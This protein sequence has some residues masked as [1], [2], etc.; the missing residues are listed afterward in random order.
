MDYESLGKKDKP[1]VY[2][3]LKNK[4]GIGLKQITIFIKLK[5]D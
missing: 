5:I 1:N 2:E 3:G 4:Q